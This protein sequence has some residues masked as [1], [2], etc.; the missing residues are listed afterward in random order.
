M[1][2]VAPPGGWTYE[3]VHPDKWADQMLKAW[4]VFNIFGYL[5]KTNSFQNERV[6]INTSRLVIAISLYKKC[7]IN[8]FRIKYNLI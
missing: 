1:V 6:A 4:K 7:N 3:P 2:H 5:E 8:C